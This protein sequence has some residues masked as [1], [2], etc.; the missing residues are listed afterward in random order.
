MCYVAQDP[1]FIHPAHD[2]QP[3]IRHYFLSILPYSRVFLQS[4]VSI[5]QKI[6]DRLQKLL[7]K[8]TKVPTKPSERRFFCSWQL[9]IMSCRKLWDSEPLW[10]N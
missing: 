6:A 8:A 1:D 3:S 9:A 7:E 2:I 4:N 5:D 10:Y